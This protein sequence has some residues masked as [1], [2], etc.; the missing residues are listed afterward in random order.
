VES[1]NLT[2]QSLTRP[3]DEQFLLLLA[4]LR[5]LHRVAIL[6]GDN[7]PIWLAVV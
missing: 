3:Y 2:E 6:H 1:L 7:C 5:R 4:R